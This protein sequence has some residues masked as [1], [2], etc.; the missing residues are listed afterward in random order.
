M[1]SPKL[2][3]HRL[4][5]LSLSTTAKKEQSDPMMH[6]CLL[7]HPKILRKMPQIS[8]EPRGGQTGYAARTADSLKANRYCLRAEWV[9][10]M[11]GLGGSELLKKKAAPVLATGKEGKG[12]QQVRSM[13]VELV[14]HRDVN[15]CRCHVLLMDPGAP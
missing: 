4:P 15:L 8:G 14:F 10:A 5:F 11:G 3:P 6:S 9:V 7:S 2:S 13:E 12:L 1:P